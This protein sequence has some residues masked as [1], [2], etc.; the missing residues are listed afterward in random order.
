M[1]G[2]WLLSIF[3]L[4]LFLLSGCS[5]GP[6]DR[7]PS[8]EARDPNRPGVSAPAN[9]E[10]PSANDEDDETQALEDEDGVQIFEDA[11]GLVS[12]R[13][14][15]GRA[16]LTYNLAQWDALHGLSALY[17][18]EPFEEGPFAIVTEG[19]RVAEACV[20]RVETLDEWGW[21]YDEFVTPAV[22][23]LMDDGT[24]E[25]AVAAPLESRMDGVP[26]GLSLQH[27]K[28]QGVL[29]VG[30]MLLAAINLGGKQ[31][32]QLHVSA[33]SPTAGISSSVSSMLSSPPHTSRSR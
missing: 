9:N 4:L 24:V 11:D 26:G 2:Q 21:D 10:E 28:S 31:S 23:L 29:Q 17:S 19:E 16:E 6:E 7:A 30:H 13:I 18:E 27:G 14:E 25:C 32:H 3:M 5:N 20:G 33:T 15:D 1:K 22:V 12:V 8:T